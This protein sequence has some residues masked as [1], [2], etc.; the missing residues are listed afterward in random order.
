MA[1]EGKWVANDDHTKRSGWIQG[2]GRVDKIAGKQVEGLP[3]KI[4]GKSDAGTPSKKLVKNELKDSRMKEET[5]D[6]DDELQLL[7]VARKLQIGGWLQ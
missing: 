4:A 6:W 2:L 7:G 3:Y 5:V 1:F